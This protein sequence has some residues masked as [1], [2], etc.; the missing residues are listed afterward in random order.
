LNVRIAD[1]NSKL[2]V[3]TQDSAEKATNIAQKNVWEKQAEQ[4][5][6]SNANIARK[7]FI[8]Q[9]TSFV[10]R[11]AFRN[12]KSNITNTRHISKM[13]TLSSFTTDTTRRAT[14]SSIE[15]LWKTFSEENF[16]KMKSFIT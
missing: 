13:V 12:I 11:N 8:A 7:N 3:Q 2:K 15:E 4:E 1:K 9:D 16:L 6:S 5:T 10:L 14:S